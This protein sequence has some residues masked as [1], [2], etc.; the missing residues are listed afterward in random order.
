MTD[1][2]KLAFW[3]KIIFLLTAVCA[4]FSLLAFYYR[5]ISESASHWFRWILHAA[6]VFNI[7][8]WLPFLFTQIFICVYVLIFLDFRPPG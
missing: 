5:L 2:L 4:A 8:T 1:S 6:V 7:V 3:A